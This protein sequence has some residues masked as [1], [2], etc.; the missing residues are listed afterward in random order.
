MTR[1]MSV[2]ESYIPREAT[3]SMIDWRHLIKRRSF[4]I[5]HVDDI[6]PYLLMPEIR[7]LLHRTTNPETHFL[8]NTMW[9]CGP[10]IT[11]ALLLTPSAFLLD[12]PDTSVVKL[13]TLKKRQK[14]KRGRPAKSLLGRPLS[15]AVKTRVVPVYSH[16]LKSE[17]LTY[18]AANRITG[19][20]LLFPRVRW[21]YNKRLEKLQTDLADDGLTF[22]V[23]LTPHVFRHSFAV[24]CL[25]NRISLS[26]IRDYLGHA[27]IKETETYTRIFTGETHA[28]M[29]NV[30]F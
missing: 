22:P 6:P 9:H 4:L 14:A 2:I 3:Q 1:I 24:H 21:T 19:D 27:N 8:I 15:P 10:R 11:E 17:L 13:T 20:Q 18:C 30:E 26:D 23:K 29:A 16:A 25:I 5:D 7:A 28:D 12:D